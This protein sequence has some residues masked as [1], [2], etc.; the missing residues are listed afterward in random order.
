VLIILVIHMQW[1]A[2]YIRHN[3]NGL[4]KNFAEPNNHSANTAADQEVF[5]KHVQLYQLYQ[6]YLCT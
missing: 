1:Y 6:R 3:C 5:L 2:A 4:R